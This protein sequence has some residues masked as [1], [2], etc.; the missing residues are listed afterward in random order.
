[1]VP[2]TSPD[3]NCSDSIKKDPLATT[4]LNSAS[5]PTDI[6]SSGSGLELIGNNDDEPPTPHLMNMPGDTIV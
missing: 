6:L 2:S 5:S 4:S 3:K 1:M